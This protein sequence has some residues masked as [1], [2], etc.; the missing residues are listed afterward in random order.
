MPRRWTDLDSDEHRL[1]EGFRRVGYDA[2]ERCHYFCDGDGQTWRSEPGNEFGVLA[3]VRPEPPVT[4]PRRP[5]PPDSKVPIDDP[6]PRV[7]ISV[8]KTFQEMFRPRQMTS[9]PPTLRKSH[10]INIPSVSLLKRSSTIAASFVKSR[11]KY[12]TKS[13]HSKEPSHESETEQP[14]TTHHRRAVSTPVTVRRSATTTT[15][16]ESSV[17]PVETLNHRSRRETT[18][19]SRET[20]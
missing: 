12:F 4:I 3:P 15:T 6:P 16:T 5:P 2:D 17:V 11:G 1:P 9:A 14:H 10:T 13:G 8:F 19:V 7:S 18:R 20:K